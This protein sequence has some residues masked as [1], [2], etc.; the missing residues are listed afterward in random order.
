[1]GLHDKRRRSNIAKKD[2]V[3]KPKLKHEKHISRIAQH[4][5]KIQEHPAHAIANPAFGRKRFAKMHIRKKQHDSHGKQQNEDAAPANRVDKK[6]ADHRRRNRS[7]AVNRANDSHSLCQI[8]AGKRIGSHRTGNHN[9]AGSA[10]ALQKAHRHKRL[11]IGCEYAKH[12]SHDKQ[13]HRQQQKRATTVLVAQRAKQK[14]PR[15]KTDHAKRQS[16]L[17]HRHRRA[18]IARHA[19]QRRKIHV[20]DQRRKRRQRPQKHIEEGSRINFSHTCLHQFFQTAGK[21]HQHDASRKTHPY[22][23]HEEIVH[24][25]N[26]IT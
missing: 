15:S 11:Y 7:N 6:A 24:V 5:P 20:R 17:D 23:Q 2:A 4:F 26:C 18:E 25:G 12:R 8:S 14:L 3:G 16:E 13:R 10:D 21:K 22:E 1:M 19:R 9:A